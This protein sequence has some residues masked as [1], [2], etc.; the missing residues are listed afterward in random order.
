[1]SAN[2]NC[3]DCP[4]E[5]WWDWS[6]LTWSCTD[7]GYRPTEQEVKILK[8]LKESNLSLQTQTVR[9][10]S[11]YK[12]ANDVSG[13]LMQ[14][15]VDLEGFAEI[16]HALK[17]RAVEAERQRDKIIKCQV[18]MERCPGEG[19]WCK[20]VERPVSGPDLYGMFCAR[21]KQECWQA[22]AAQKDAVLEV[23]GRQSCKAVTPVIDI[24]DSVVI[25]QHDLIQAIDLFPCEWDILLGLEGKVV[26]TKKRLSAEESSLYQKDLIILV[27]YDHFLS[28]KGIK[29]INAR[30]RLYELTAHAEEAGVELV[31]QISDR[32]RTAS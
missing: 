20:M 16:N 32:E 7:C 9:A 24:P 23:S 2:I 19:P 27:G 21:T 11:E 15:S 29:A 31:S 17:A 30:R 8:K 22:F 12:R 1:M 13:K 10:D 5:L 18:D 26:T 6:T 4:S 14:M 25:A 3:P 28:P